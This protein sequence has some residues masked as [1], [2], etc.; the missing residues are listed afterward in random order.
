MKFFVLTEKTGSRK[1]DEVGYFSS[2]E[3]ADEIK[4]T[5]DTE[6]DAQINELELFEGTAQDWLARRDAVAREAILN[7]LSD[8]ERKL[9]GL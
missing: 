3:V 5:F 9:L 7:K 4:G 2:A 6:A 1:R 8:S